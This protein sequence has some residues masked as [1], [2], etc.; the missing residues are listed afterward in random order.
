MPKLSSAARDDRRQ[1][2][3]RAA[4]IC[5]ARDGFH[6]TT[7]ADV[8]RQAGVSTGAIYTYFPNKESIIRAIFEQAHR[9]RLADLSGAA[10][11]AEVGLAQAHVLLD[12]LQGVFSERGQHFARVDANFWTEA[13][14]NPLVAQ[15]AR[16]ALT[17]ATQAVSTVVSERMGAQ[18]LCTAITPQTVASILVSIFLGV[19]IQTVVGIPL[20]PNEIISVLS[21][22]FARFLEPGSAP[23]PPQPTK[24]EEGD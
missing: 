6:R 12:W 14:R 5:F 15:I 9:D 17:D 18:T 21:L 13:L 16:Q 22:L 1:H 19:E 11:S 8:R 10:N 20:D 2:I 23:Q 7:I 3:L 24:G 4:E